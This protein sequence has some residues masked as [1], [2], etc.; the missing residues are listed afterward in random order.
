MS[1]SIPEKNTLEYSDYLDEIIEE[2][3]AVKSTLKRGNMRKENR[4]EVNNLQN[5]ITALRH[6]KRRNNR[7]L[8]DESKI[9][10]NNRPKK[11]NE[12]FGHDMIKDFLRGICHE[13]K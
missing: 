8:D 11:L 1:K 4:K 12:N 13:D 3:T 6:L 9:L 10:L 2:L 5:A 7:K